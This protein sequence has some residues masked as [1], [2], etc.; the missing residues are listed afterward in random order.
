MVEKLTKGSSSTYSNQAHQA[1]RQLWV[2]VNQVCRSNILSSSPRGLS[3]WLFMSV[4]IISACINRTS[5]FAIQLPLQITHCTSRNL[6]K[7]RLVPFGK[8]EWVHREDNS[9][10]ISA[11]PQRNGVLRRDKRPPE[12][13]TT[14]GVTVKCSGLDR[15]GILLS[16]QW[17]SGRKLSR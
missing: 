3:L 7:M 1:L 6:Q 4:V 8:V 13:G 10:H 9:D 17:P 5:G 16:P 11:I 14:M 12:I 2:R 15:A